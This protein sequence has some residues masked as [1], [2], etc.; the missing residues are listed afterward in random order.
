[1]VGGIFMPILILIKS[2]KD[3]ELYTSNISIEWCKLV[4]KRGLK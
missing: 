2:I 4:L 3:C 1:M